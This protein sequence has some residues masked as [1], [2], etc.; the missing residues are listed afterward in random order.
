[1]TSL[2]KG[3]FDRTLAK[4]EE[5]DDLKLVIGDD[6]AGPFGPDPVGR[7]EVRTGTKLAKVVTIG[8]VVPQ[9]GMDS[10]M[11]FAFLPADSPIPHFTLDSVEAGGQLAFHLDLVPRAD[12][13]SH[14]GYLDAAFEPLTPSF[15][16]SKELFGASRAAIGPRQYAM[17]SPW[18][19][20][21]RADAEQFKQVDTFVDDYFGHWK[22]LV[23]G[24]LP[25]DV[26]ATLHDTDLA[27]RD[28]LNRSYLFSPEVDPVWANVTRLVGE[29]TSARLRAHLMSN[30][31]DL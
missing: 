13:A 18:M 11:I 25:D 27:A 3:L 2:P 8:L 7:L 23:E 12:L 30:E 14:L 29:E 19:L 20:V 9:I 1:M 6:L 22:G 26:V 21:H 17:M 15:D 4:L 5:T 16:R 10:H 28:A 31:V 24:G